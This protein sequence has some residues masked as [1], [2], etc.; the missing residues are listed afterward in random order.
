MGLLF[1]LGLFLWAQG[2]AAQGRY[3]TT[4]QPVCTLGAEADQGCAEI[5][6]REILDASADPWRAIGRVN[7]AS[8]SQ[9]SHCTGVMISDR[10]VLTAAH[11]LYNA[12]RKRWIPATSIRF[13]AGYQRGEAVS[14]ST[15]SAYHMD[16][17]QGVA[18]QFDTSAEL[19]WAILELD[20]PLGTDAGFLPLTDH[21]TGDAFVAGYPALRRHVL[22]RT[23]N[24]ASHRQ[25]QALLLANCPVMKGDSGAPLLVQTDTGLAVAGILSRIAPTPNGI[26]ALFLSSQLFQVP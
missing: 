17:A 7:F 12:A 26:D 13:A 23:G 25:A 11:C 16:P 20:Q 6:A 22:S 8:R 21:T 14:V 4:W 24:C 3:S 15:A 2:A 1:V 19:D 9:R 10:H 18:G 5:R